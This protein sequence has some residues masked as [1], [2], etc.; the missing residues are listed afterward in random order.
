MNNI[1]KK[2]RQSYGDMKLSYKFTLVLLL[3]ATVPVVM[4]AC[5]FYGKLYDMVVSYTIRQEQDA[6]AQTS[7]YIEDLVQQIIDAHTGITDQEFFQTLFHQPVNSPFQMF[8]DSGSAQDFHDYAEELIDSDMI[9][10]I[11][12]YMDFPP[13]SVRLFNDELTKDY[14]SP[15][16]LAR[17]TYWYG[18]F[19]GTQQ[20]S[21]YCPEFYLGGREKK[22]YGDLAYI[23][24]TTFYYQGNAR[25]AYIAVYSSSDHLNEMLKDNLKLDGSVSYIIND[26]DAVVATSDTSLS[27]IYLLDYDTIENS[28][29]SSNNFIEREI[30]DTTV[31][32]GFYNIKQPGWF[33]VTV[34]PSG[35]L[36]KQSNMIMVQYILMYLA[37]L[38]FALLLSHYMSHSITNRISS[39]IHQM[40]KVRKGSLS[41]M[42]SPQYHD[43]IG[44][45]IDTYNYMTRKMDQLMTDQAK[46]A[47]ELRIAEFRTLQAQINP[48]F[49][50]N[51][52][53]MINWLAQ[54][55]RTDEVSYAVQKLSRFYKLT[56]SR[57]QSISTIASETEHV[58]IYLQI[59]NMR[60][61]DSITFI[62]DIPDELMEY[63]IPKLTLQPIIENSVLHGILETSDKTGTIVLTGWLEDSDIVLLISDNGVGI[64]PEKLDTL[65][66]EKTIT[67]TT[68]AASGTNI[69]V[70]NTHRRLQILYGPDYGLSYTSNPGQGTEVEIRIP[71]RKHSATL[72]SIPPLYRK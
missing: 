45:L 21:L 35:P 41:P 32:A 1:I 10:G 11:Q 8:L 9:T 52:M 19:Q 72:D 16:S 3:T 29:M 15:L 42:N 61:R 28:F 53:D 65:L 23:T 34:L 44:D 47:E 30:L 5:F 33:M 54:Q 38:I 68:N 70:Y 67:E 50:Y 12:I 58:S 2:C 26:R 37:F 27:G 62:C 36:I 43:E 69:A 4:M 14:F 22:K 57:K 13:Q 48:H 31:Y 64:P 60:F 66:V 59:Q 7:P 51:T 63:Q 24:S 6:S 56:L 40:S 25:Q 46:A 20:S 39:V 49:L 18:I 17:G 71:A 55:G